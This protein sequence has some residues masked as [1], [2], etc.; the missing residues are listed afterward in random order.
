MKGDPEVFTLEELQSILKE[1]REPYRTLYWLAAE[2]G[3]RAGE[4]C[5][6][7]WEDV[8][9][10]SG[11]VSVRQSAYLGVIQAPKSKAAYRTFAISTELTSHLRNQGRGTG[12]VFVNKLGQPFKGGKIA[13]RKLKPLLQRLGIRKRGLHAFRRANATLLDHLNVPMK[14]RQDRLGHTDP[15]VTMKHYTRA[16][17]GDDR[18]AADDLGKILCPIVSNDVKEQLSRQELPFNTSNLEELC[19]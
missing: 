12:L 15:R 14:V 3:M 6:L 5:G 8:H 7:R 4:L 11:V 18:K 19:S 9:F 10:E 16:T 1:A 13:E 17:S 2:T